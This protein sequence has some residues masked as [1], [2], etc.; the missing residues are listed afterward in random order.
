[1]VRRGEIREVTHR[2]TVSVLE[3]KE[4]RFR[5]SVGGQHSRWFDTR[6]EAIW[7]MIE[8]LDLESY[9]WK[10]RL[11]ALAKESGTD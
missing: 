11:D 8:W 2:P 3:S 1:M 9:R 10:R 4:G 6:E 7:E 5:A